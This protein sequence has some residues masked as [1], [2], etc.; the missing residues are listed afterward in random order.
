MN[1]WGGRFLVLIFVLL[2]LGLLGKSLSSLLSWSKS[3]HQTLE[4]KL[5]EGNQF[6]R[7]ALL[8]KTAETCSKTLRSL[9]EGECKQ[10]CHDQAV[11]IP[12]SIPEY[13]G[14]GKVA[15]SF[16]RNAKTTGD[17]K[18]EIGSTLRTIPIVINDDFCE[19]DP[20]RAKFESGAYLNQ[21][22]NC[23]EP[24]RQEFIR[25]CPSGKVMVLSPGKTPEFLCC[26][27][28]A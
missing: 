1:Q 26:P 13:S 25:S 20:V 8:F 17:L 9:F 19:V 23:T 18:V 24:W 28:G 16:S 7:L 4:V 11:S 10:T 27:L 3:N 12:S 21:D 2:S 15:V 6:M 14:D 22:L 5:N